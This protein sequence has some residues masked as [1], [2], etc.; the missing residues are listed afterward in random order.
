MSLGGGGGTEPLCGVGGG[1]VVL[2]PVNGGG[3]PNL[4]PESPGS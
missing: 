2:V 3:T 4:E 1:A